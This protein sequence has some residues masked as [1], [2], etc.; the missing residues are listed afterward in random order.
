[1]SSAA[2]SCWDEVPVLNES[3][4]I[5][6]STP[7]Q[8]VLTLPSRYMNGLRPTPVH[9]KLQWFAANLWTASFHFTNQP[10]LSYTVYRIHLELSDGEN[11]FSYPFDFANQCKN[12]GLSLVP[13]DSYSI[14]KSEL[15]AE[16]LNSTNA[17]IRVRLWAH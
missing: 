13:G 17:S 2:S 6:L 10:N 14:L 1:M 5:D 9:L 8:L 12:I 15:P 11:L 3:W 4:Q 7:S 16:L